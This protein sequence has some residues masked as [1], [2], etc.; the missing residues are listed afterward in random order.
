M[1][2]HSVISTAEALATLVVLGLVMGVIVW[3]AYMTR[4]RAH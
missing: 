4:W 3:M 1:G 2:P